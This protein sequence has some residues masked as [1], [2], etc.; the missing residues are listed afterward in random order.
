MGWLRRVF[1][2]SRKEIW[3]QFCDE[4]GGQYHV[5]GFLKSDKV[6]IR[7]GAWTT[8]LDTV[9]Q[10]AGQH[11]QTYTRIR[12]PY[13]N[14]GG[15]RFTIYRKTIFTGI[16]KLLGMQDVEVGDPDFDAAFVVRGNDE[17]RLRALLANERIRQLIAMQP[18]IYFT[19]KDDE[20]R[21]GPKFPK[22]VDEIYFGVA[23][24]IKD[25]DRLKALYY[26]FVETLNHLCQIGA[27][28]EDDPNLEL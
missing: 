23:G 19:V 17:G 11:S 7:H 6:I 25:L 10:N 12:A 5:G 22:E 1:G 16:G 13:V 15:F 28:S 21:F 8:V 9:N 24:V 2:P 18:A 3:H 4:V 14:P 26:L 27:A 20:G